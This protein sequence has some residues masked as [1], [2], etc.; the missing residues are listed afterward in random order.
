MCIFFLNPWLPLLLALFSLHFVF[1]CMPLACSHWAPFSLQSTVA[2]IADLAWT[3]TFF[4]C[5]LFSSCVVRL[6]IP[7]I[8]GH[9]NTCTAELPPGRLVTSEHTV[10]LLSSSGCVILCHQDF[11]FYFPRTNNTEHLFLGVFTVNTS[12][13]NYLIKSLIHLKTQVVNFKL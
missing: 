12:L 6:Y 8:P 5:M 4:T 13:L 2:F 1:P 10:T 7:E 3:Y 9:T 11:S